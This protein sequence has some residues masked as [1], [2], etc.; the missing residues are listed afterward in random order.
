M[1]HHCD[2]RGYRPRSNIHIS[3]NDDDTITICKKCKRFCVMECPEG[4]TGCYVACITG[5]GTFW[6]PL[7]D[8]PTGSGSTGP[9]GP[10][11]TF[12]IETG[13]GPTG[14]PTTGPF[15]VS[16]GDT[17]RFWSNTLSINGATGSVLVNIEAPTGLG[18]TGPTGEQGPAGAG[19]T[20]PTGADGT[21]GADGSTGPTGEQGPAGAGSTGPTGA[22]GPVGPQGPTG[23][24][25]NVTTLTLPVRTGDTVNKDEVVSLLSDGTVTQGFSELSSTNIIDGRN[26]V[27][28]QLDTA[29]DTSAV[30]YEKP[31]GSFVA[32]I[33]QSNAPSTSPTFGAELTI[34]S[35]GY[36]NK[37][38]RLNSTRF[39]L[40]WTNGTGLVT[41]TAY[42]VAGLVITQ[43]TGGLSLSTN[44]NNKQTVAPLSNGDEFVL[45]DKDSLVITALINMYH[46]TVVG[47]NIVSDGSTL[48]VTSGSGV[49]SE[50]TDFPVE[51]SV[52]TFIFG[53]YLNTFNRLNVV[54]WDG[55][56]FVGG[57]TTV[58]SFSPVAGMLSMSKISDSEIIVSSDNGLYSTYSIVL[59]V[60]TAE[61]L[62]A[63]VGT[64]GA[65]TVSTLDSDNVISLSTDPYTTRIVH[66][67]INSN[68]PFDVT[69]GTPLTLS[70]SGIVIYVSDTMAIVTTDTGIT[71][72][73]VDQGTNSL[74]YY[75]MFGSTPL[76]LA[77]STVLIASPG[78]TLNV[79]VDGL[80]NTTNALTI[81]ALYYVH[82]DGTVN[83]S[84]IVDDSTIQ[85]DKPTQLGIAISS[86]SILLN[87][88]SK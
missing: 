60:I 35:S 87:W 58:V 51:L 73:S 16:N 5:T 54:T 17:V 23:V 86:N 12:F 61:T 7:P 19:S 53:T 24:G 63:A 52:S 47:T 67:T 66:G 41:L 29:A 42:D 14:P 72:L 18:S 25:S 85:I 9:T 43:L 48:G 70:R 81:G 78:D 49:T 30:V 34:D 22:G 50:F 15:L 69:W 55:A 1:G 10:S 27:S 44:A 21:D 13:T 40:V 33:V 26:I 76:G 56:G 82:G 64:T 62:N 46:F 8:S 80:H 11:T 31:D 84:N 37:I 75:D 57:L 68:S 6:Q 74:D 28:I 36:N 4:P 3:K 83:L 20:G 88:P 38:Y 65:T 79:T 45:L 32:R 39:A 71:S 77:N 59:D 2:C